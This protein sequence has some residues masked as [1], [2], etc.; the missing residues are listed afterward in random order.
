MFAP[1]TNGVAQRASSKARDSASKTRR[2]IEDAWEEG[3]EV[4]DEIRQHS[5][6]TGDE[7]PEEAREEVEDEYRPLMEDESSRPSHER[8]AS[9]ESAL[10]GRSG[11][12]EETVEHKA[13]SVEVALA[14]G[15]FF[16]LGAC[17]LL[18]WNS[19]IVAGAYFL[20][21]LVDSPYETSYSSWVALTFVS[22]APRWTSAALGA[23]LSF[24]PQTTGNLLFLAYANA[25]QQGAHLGRRIWGSIVVLI[26]TVSLYIVSTRIHEIDPHV[27]FS[28][29]IVCTIILAASA[30][31][32]QN[33]VVALSASFG[34]I[35]LQA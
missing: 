2:S 11:T 10:V 27:F 6:R 12:A 34:P 22:S 35:F 21:R 17:I 26:V 3:R 23:D 15:C 29:L 5:A 1:L 28:S 19:E 8:S 24:E 31:Y 14:Y 18:A 32:L 7:T 9:Y 30:S 4:A 13:R 16:T 33:A 20:S 25:T